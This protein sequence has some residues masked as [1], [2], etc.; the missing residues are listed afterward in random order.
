MGA[1]VKCEDSGFV[2]SEVKPASDT[3]SLCYWTH[4]ITA[5]HGGAFSGKSVINNNYFISLL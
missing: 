1:A 5:P 4:N 2:L 3:S